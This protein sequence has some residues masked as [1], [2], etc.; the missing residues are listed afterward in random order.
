MPAQ[1]D[2]TPRIQAAPVDPTAAGL[3]FAGAVGDVCARFEAD[4]EMLLEWASTSDEGGCPPDS[5]LLRALRG[6]LEEAGLLAPKVRGIPH[7]RHTWATYD[8]DQVTTVQA[9]AENQTPR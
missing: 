9:L 8:G 6:T 2:L 7:R 1:M 4:P 5:R 3:A